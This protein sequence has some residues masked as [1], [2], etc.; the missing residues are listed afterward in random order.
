MKRDNNNDISSKIEN[1]VDLCDECKKY[2]IQYDEPYF[3]EMSSEKITGANVPDGWF[4]LEDDVNDKPDFCEAII[5]YN[6]YAISIKILDIFKFFKANRVLTKLEKK[7]SIR[8]YNRKEKE[9]YI[10]NYR[11]EK[12]TELKKAKAIVEVAKEEMKLEK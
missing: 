8:S 2:G 6:R 4:Y 10:E 12:E 9:E 7:Y 3:I 5:N 11:K 1:E